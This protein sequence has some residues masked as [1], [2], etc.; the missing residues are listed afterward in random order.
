[1]LGI[2][3]NGG[4]RLIQKRRKRNKGVKIYEGLKYLLFSMTFV[5]IYSVLKKELR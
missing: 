5:T 3:T 1:M 2:N 4:G